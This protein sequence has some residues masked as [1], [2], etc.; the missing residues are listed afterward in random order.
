M[1]FVLG[2]IEQRRLGTVSQICFEAYADIEDRF[3]LLARNEGPS[4]NFRV[5]KNSEVARELLEILLKTEWAYGV[6]AFIDEEPVG[7]GFL[8]LKESIAS[9]GPLFVAPRYQGR[10]VGRALLGHLIEYADLKQL[11]SVRLIQDACA[12]GALALATSL[13]FEVKA[14]LMSMRQHGGSPNIRKI[15]RF[16]E[17]DVTRLEALAKR[18]C[19]DERL[20]P[21][22]GLALN[23]PSF[24]ECDPL[25]H[26]QDGR[27][28][29]YLIPGTLGHGMAESSDIAITLVNHAVWQYPFTDTRFM[30]FMTNSDLYRRIQNLNSEP[31]RPFVLMVR[32][33]FEPIRGNWLPPLFCS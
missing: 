6:I 31:I 22:L 29:G 26:E 4:G 21:T 19:P 16:T 30:C 3:R 12:L 14:Q 13:G 17:S 18:V 8:C 10:G 24:F 11:K 1:A 23:R 2:S 32:G 33:H 9:V 7:C 27:I 5:F 28:S 25:I 20:L 15:R